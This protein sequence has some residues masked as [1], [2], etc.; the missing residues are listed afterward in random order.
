VNSLEFTFEISASEWL[1]AGS[2]TKRFILEEGIVTKCEG[3]NAKWLKPKPEG[4][5]AN[6]LSEI[7]EPTGL[8]A[9]YGLASDLINEIVP[10]S[11]EYFLGAIETV[12][13][14]DLAEEDEGE[15]DEDDEDE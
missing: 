8:N 14:E 15:G 10:Y 11:I 1:K 6:L 2:I 3:D 12:D 7:T 5:L 13:E 9:A 4:L